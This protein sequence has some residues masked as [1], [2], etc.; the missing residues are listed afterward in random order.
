MY[1][2]GLRIVDPIENGQ[3]ELDTDRPVD[4]EPCG[5]DEFVFPVSRAARISAREIR[6]WDQSAV[7]PSLLRYAQSCRKH[8]ETHFVRLTN[9]RHSR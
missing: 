2:D 7:L 1:R 4:P 3:F 9:F 8:R 5:T 6:N